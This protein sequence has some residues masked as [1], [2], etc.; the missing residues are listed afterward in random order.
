MKNVLIRPVVTEKSN[1]LQEKLNRYVFVVNSDANKLQV[2][3][4][5]ENMY[6]VSVDA[7]NTYIVPGKMKN[8]QTKSGIIT[9]KTVS[10]KKAVITLAKGEEIDFYANI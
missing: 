1:E 8:R 4:A 3:E 6:G 2:K 9:G 10:Y 7:V 5:V